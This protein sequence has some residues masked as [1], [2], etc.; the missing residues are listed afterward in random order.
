MKI[1]R[2]KGKGWCNRGGGGV[3]IIVAEWVG[4]CVCERCLWGG[5]DR[6][7]TH[8]MDRYHFDCAYVF[9]VDIDSFAE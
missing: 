3:H 7:N 6:E 5:V 4:R 9:G 2:R 1:N 8:Q